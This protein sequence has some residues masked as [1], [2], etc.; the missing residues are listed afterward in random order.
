M[1]ASLLRIAIN[2]WPPLLGAGIRVRHISADFRTVRV[3]LRM[4]LLNRNYVGTHF[5]GSLFAMTDP[6]Y[7]LMLLHNL[8]KDYIVWDQAAR[9]TFIKP[10]RGAVG[11]EFRLDQA[12]LDAIRS[13]TASGQK[14]LQNFAIDIRDAQGEVVASVM[15]TLYIRQKQVKA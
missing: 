4:G 9:I 8:G 6:F 15:K 5:G 2:C 3:V 14:H 1:N 10:G 13:A 7:M 11:C 12:L